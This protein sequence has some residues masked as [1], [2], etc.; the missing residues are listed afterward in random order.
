MAYLEE[1]QTCNPRLGPGFNSHQSFGQGLKFLTNLTNLLSRN[2]GKT[3][4]TNDFHYFPLLHLHAHK[5]CACR[6]LS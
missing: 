3:Q 5:F 1:H 6:S 4:L 2:L